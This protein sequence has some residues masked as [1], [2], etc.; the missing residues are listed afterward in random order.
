MPKL[1]KVELDQLEPGYEFPATSYEL[2]PADVATYLRAVEETS[3]LYQT[4]LVPPMAVAAY[5]MSA[6]SEGLSLPPGAIHISQE[7]EFLDLV[8]VGDTITC[9]ARFSQKHSRGRLNIMSIEL[10][11]FNQKPKKVLAGKTSFILPE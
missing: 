7:L 11:V 10:N 1:P 8:R 9:R 6:L 3:P 4:G 5:A 2:A